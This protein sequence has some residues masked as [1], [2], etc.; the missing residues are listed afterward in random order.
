VKSTALALRRDGDRSD[1]GIER[2]FDDPIQDLLICLLF[3]EPVAHMQALGDAVPESDADAMPAPVLPLHHE[4][5]HFPGCDHQFSIGQR[6]IDRHCRL[7]MGAQ[8][9]KREHQQNDKSLQPFHPHQVLSE[10]DKLACRLV[11]GSRATASLPAPGNSAS[12]AEIERP[13]PVLRCLSNK[14][15]QSSLHVGDPQTGW[16]DE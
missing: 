3:R 4:R 7:R 12:S 8:A 1:P 14:K 6:R 9:S 10:A 13:W 16:S 2:A 15:C 11:P 5:G